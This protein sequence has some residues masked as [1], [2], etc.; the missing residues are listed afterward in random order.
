MEKHRYPKPNLQ[1]WVESDQQR[2]VPNHPGGRGRRTRTA[3]CPAQLKH[4]EQ[5]SLRVE[6]QNRNPKPT[7]NFHMK[8][9]NQSDFLSQGI[10]INSARAA[11][12]KE[13]ESAKLRRKIR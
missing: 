9:K 5:Y 10:S 7:Y 2:V 8:K 3:R 1:K 6:E 13:I 12:K 11:F 4:G